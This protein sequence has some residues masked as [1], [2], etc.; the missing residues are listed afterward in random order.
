MPAGITWEISGIERQ[1]L[2]SRSV[3]SWFYC[4]VKQNMI[5]E[6][7][8]EFP[9]CKYVSRGISCQFW[10]V[11]FYFLPPNFSKFCWNE[12][13]FSENVPLFELHKLCKNHNYWIM[14]AQVVLNVKSLFI[15]IWKK[16]PI[17]GHFVTLFISF[18][19]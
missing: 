5:K 15:E 4:G 7:F 3:I 6:R 9:A 1:N 11:F 17:F 2:T 16:R 18:L 13:Q 8:E 19:L 10:P 12:L 14:F